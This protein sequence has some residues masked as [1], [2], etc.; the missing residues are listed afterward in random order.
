MTIPHQKQKHVETLMYF[1][2]VKQRLKMVRLEISALF[3]MDNLIYNPLHT[4][5]AQLCGGETTCMVWTSLFSHSSHNYFHHF[6][7]EQMSATL[8]MPLGKGCLYV[9]FYRIIVLGILPNASIFTPASSGVRTGINPSAFRHVLQT[10][11]FK[12]TLTFIIL[13]HGRRSLSSCLPAQVNL[14]LI[15][16]TIFCFLTSENDPMKA[17]KNPLKDLETHGKPTH[18]I[19]IVLADYTWSQSCVGTYIFGFIISSLTPLFCTS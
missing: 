11:N 3:D 6:L 9:L 4:V 7:S 13:L 17:N 1:Q 2:M 19:W 5:I 10:G 16:T 12:Q 15:M 8:W 14:V 18:V